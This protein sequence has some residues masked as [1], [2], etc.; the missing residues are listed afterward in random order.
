M[1]RNIL[2]EA[3]SEL[4]KTAVTVVRKLKME[5]ER[6]QVSFVGGVFSAGELVIAPLREELARIARKAFIAEPRFS[7]TI[8]AGRMAQEQLHRLP[9]AV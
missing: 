9:L 5:R 4:G 3:G 1:A 7:P 6:F 8:A 2:I